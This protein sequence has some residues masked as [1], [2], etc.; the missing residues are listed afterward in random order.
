MTDRPELPGAHGAGEPPERSDRANLVVLAVALAVLLGIVALVWFVNT[1]QDDD[2][3]ARI[4]S[5]AAGF[6]TFDDDVVAAPDR[7]ADPV[8]GR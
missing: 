5:A 2:R 3:V 4:R 6:A 1:A 7:P 8:D